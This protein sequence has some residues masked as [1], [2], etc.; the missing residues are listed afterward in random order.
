MLLYDVQPIK[1]W[2]T[3]FENITMIFT[4]MYTFSLFQIDYFLTISDNATALSELFCNQDRFMA[5][6]DVRRGVDLTPILSSMC[7][8]D[9]NT[10]AQELMD[11][12]KIAAL[13]GDVRLVL[14]LFTK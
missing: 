12:L 4:K 7:A 8:L 1:I 13:S 6:F 14:F 11:S 2:K 5:V 3:I 9:F 10:I